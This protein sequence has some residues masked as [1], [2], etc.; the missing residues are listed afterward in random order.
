MRIEGSRKN[1]QES[2]GCMMKRNRRYIRGAACGRGADA[3]SVG[4]RCP[5]GDALPR[6]FARML[7]GVLRKD[8]SQLCPRETLSTEPCHGQLTLVHIPP[9][10]KAAQAAV[11]NGSHEIR[12]FQGKG[13]WLPRALSQMNPRPS[14]GRCRG[15]DGAITFRLG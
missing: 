8:G 5:R 14:P 3:R 13:C 4:R 1:E 6:V 11:T 2:Q 9:V 7:G 15:A 12:S 10:P